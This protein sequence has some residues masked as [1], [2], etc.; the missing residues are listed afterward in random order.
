MTSYG[1]PG[2]A[3]LVLRSRP[4]RALRTNRGGGEA[5]RQGGCGASAVRSGGGRGV[6]AGSR[7]EGAP[8]Y[9]LTTSYH[10]VARTSRPPTGLSRPPQAS[11][12]AAGSWHC[13]AELLRRQPRRDR[14]SDVAFIHDAAAAYCNAPARKANINAVVARVRGHATGQRH[15]GSGIAKSTSTSIAKTCSNTYA[16]MI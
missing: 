1:Q 6:R 9:P 13:T 2:T 5:Q 16:I 4:R 11:A 3:V 8:T 12:G 10:L 15:A 7:S 14:G